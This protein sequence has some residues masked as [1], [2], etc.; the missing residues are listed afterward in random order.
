MAPV[1][2]RGALHDVHESVEQGGMAGPQLQP[3]QEAKYVAGKLR[4][5]LHEGPCGQPPSILT[6]PV[7]LCRQ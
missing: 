6:E 5:K 7:H 1:G 3:L 2:L 4:E